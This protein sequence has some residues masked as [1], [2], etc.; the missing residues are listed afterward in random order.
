VSAYVKLDLRPLLRF[1]HKVRA[2]SGAFRRAIIQWG[3]RYRG[4]ARARFVRYSAGGGDWPRL[5]PSTL[6]ARRRR[7]KSGYVF[8]INK[9]GKRVRRGFKEGASSQLTAAPRILWDRGLLIGATRA[10][11]THAPGQLQEEI[12][13]GLRVGYGGPA[14]YPKGQI[15]I[16]DIAHAHQTGAKHL[17]VRKIIVE[18]DTKTIRDMVGD[19]ERAIEREGN[20]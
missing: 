5:K 14:R 9:A 10:T 13:E 20:G 3:A 16:A 17:P 12:P 19:L 6:A 7:V 1:A 18:P 2:R 4:F 11:F 15:T 8:R